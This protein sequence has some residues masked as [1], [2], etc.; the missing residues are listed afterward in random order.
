MKK[1]RDFSFLMAFVALI[2]FSSGIIRHDVDEKKYLDLAKSKQFEAVGHVFIGTSAGGSCVL[3][4]DKFILSAAHV[5]MESDYRQDTIT[6]NGNTMI[7]SVPFN[8]RVVDES[9]VFIVINGQKV[10][11]QKI[12][13]HPGFRDPA[14]AG[15]CDLAILELKTPFKNLKPVSIN[16]EFNEFGAEVTGVGYGASGVA[17]KIESVSQKSQKIAGQNVIDSIGGKEYMNK[18]TILFC[19]FD[20]PERSDCNKMGDSKPRPLEYIISGGDSGGPLFRQKNNKWEL[21]GICTGGGVD[22]QQLL[23]TGYYGQVMAWTRVSSFHSWI[24]E[25]VK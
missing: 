20:H 11:V 1:N 19:D 24:T 4:H 6:Y 14:T 18:K 25:H 22:V 2:V 23:K 8:E 7:S 5:F 15:S 17:D 9:K 10:G 13:M 12:Y 3:I 16:K 21:I